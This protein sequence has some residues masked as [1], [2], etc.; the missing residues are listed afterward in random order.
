MSASLGFSTVWME[1]G[2]LDGVN[3][4]TGT[5]EVPAAASGDGDGNRETVT[6]L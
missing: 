6:W 2:T 5:V 4:E 1:L 3:D